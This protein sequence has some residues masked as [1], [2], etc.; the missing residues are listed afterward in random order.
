M[1]DF[2]IH[3]DNPENNATRKFN[4]TFKSLGFKAHV[5]SPTHKAGHTLDNIISNCESFPI[6]VN[7]EESGLSDHYFVHCKLNIPKPLVLKKTVVNRN[8]KSINFEDFEKDLENLHLPSV[9]QDDIDSASEV[10]NNRLSNLLDK[11]A[12]C[13]SKTV[14]VRPNKKWFNSNLRQARTVKRRL[15]FKYNKSKL[16]KDKSALNEQK[17]YYN[18]LLNEAKCNF[19]TKAVSDAKNNI[20]HLFSVTKNILNWNFELIL[21]NDRKISQLPSDF[22]GFFIDKIAKI[23]V[24]IASEQGQSIKSYVKE[25]ALNSNS[26]LS[27]FSPASEDEIRRIIIASS[28]ASCCLDPLPTQLVKLYS[29]ILLPSITK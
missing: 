25:L 9:I 5:Y 19:N 10:Y 17:K 14:T 12:P 15:Q 27:E 1:G 28:P 29:E 18:F 3:F 7:V 16:E 20:K 2:N 8:I 6:S 24:Q 21:P 11:H 22:A 4:E 23:N 13:S 26:T